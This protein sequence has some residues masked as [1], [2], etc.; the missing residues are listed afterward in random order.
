MKFNV[1]GPIKYK[2]VKVA[3]TDNDAALDL[4]GKF[5]VD[6]AG[7]HFTPEVWEEV[8]GELDFPA[9]ILSMWMEFQQALLP[10]TRGA[11]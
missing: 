4:M 11:H 5:A 9:G 1:D 7:A 6:E 2:Q 8:I 3:Q 10:P